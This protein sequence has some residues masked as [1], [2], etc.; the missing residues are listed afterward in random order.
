LRPGSH[1]VQFN[2]VYPPGPAHRHV[3]ASSAG[4]RAFRPYLIKLSTDF[5]IFVAVWLVLLG[6]HTLSTWLP[7][8][9][10]ISQF[11]I[12]FHETVVALTFVWLSL[13]AT[14][15]I[16]MLRRKGK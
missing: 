4:W 15:D 12:G 2:E 3:S 7:L 6:A 5:L 13:E 16:V 10:T 1:A 11:L 14:W 8:G 9:T